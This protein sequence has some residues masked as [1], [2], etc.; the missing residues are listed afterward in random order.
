M[1]HHPYFRRQRGVSLIEALVALAVMALGM[2]AIAGIQATMRLNADVARQRTEANR[3]AQ[4]EMEA[5]R[6]FVQ[7]DIEAGKL[8]WDDIS[9]DGP[10]DVAVASANTT[11]SLQ[12]RVLT[13]DDPAHKVLQVSVAWSDRNGQPQAVILNSVIAGAEPKLS[14]LLSVAPSA[15]A[16]DRPRG[17]HPSIPVNARELG[18][19]T[20]GFIPRAG[21]T[22]AWVFDNTSGVIT[23]VCSVLGGTT[24]QLLTSA[25]LQNCT[26][27]TAQLVSGAVR[28]NH[29]AGDADLTAAD[30]ENPTGP[31]L[32]L[33]VLLG[34][35]SSGHANP[36][37]CFDD[38][39]GTQSQA[40]SMQ[41][42]I[43]Y[44]IIYPNTAQTW[45]GSSTLAP[46]VF[47]D[48]NVAWGVTSGGTHKVCRYTTAS[49]DATV[50]ANHPRAYASVQGNLVNQNFLVIVSAKSC[51]I[52]VA[53]SPATGDF[54]NSNTLLH[55][56]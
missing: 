39:P 25:D 32:N 28:F 2:L 50:N 30:S 34:L 1:T 38:A 17:R 3:I 26:Q 21:A 12:R 8:T 55:Q 10:N 27:T 54:V 48:T 19:G 18:N 44:C 11:F 31:P 56:P 20:S 5:M 51:P 46:A 42:V 45:S 22:V 36:P 35:T 52:D 15:T 47:S 7:M 49:T 33:D 14:G 23:S 9:D 41:A 29:Y 40:Y 16:I 37:A 6:A 43:Y 24:N 4:T 53:V 13:I